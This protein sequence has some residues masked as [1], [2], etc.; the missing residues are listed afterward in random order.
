MKQII[1]NPSG[2]NS[3][4][5]IVPDRF[6]GS[7][8]KHISFTIIGQKRLFLQVGIRHKKSPGRLHLVLI[9]VFRGEKVLRL[10]QSTLIS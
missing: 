9:A 10:Y 6:A 2:R 5:I 7:V 8:L 3:L 1:S 4:R